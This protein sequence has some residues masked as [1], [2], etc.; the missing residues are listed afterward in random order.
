MVVTLVTASVALGGSPAGFVPSAGA[1]TAA[2]A[3]AATVLP[4]VSGPLVGGARTGRPFMSAFEDLA[5]LGY[6]EEEYLLSGV[7]TNN[8]L[9][10]ALD[11][12]SPVLFRVTAAPERTAPFT[13][14][15]QVIRPVDP[16]D[17][18][19]TALV[20]WNNVTGGLDAPVLWA[21]TRE[22]ILADGYA[23]V[24]VTAQKTGAMSG[25]LSL[26]NWDRVR[27]RGVSHPG[28][29]FAF[30]IFTQAAR[31]VK[32][33]R[34]G[35][36]DP[37]GGLL[38]E[39]VI[40][41]GASQSG[42]T[43]NIYIDHVQERAG[44]VDGFMPTVSAVAKVR[45]DL[46]PVLWVDS[47]AETLQA[48]EGH[49]PDSGLYRMWEIAGASHVDWYALQALVYMALRSVLPPVLHPLLPAYDADAAIQYGERSYGGSCPQNYFP[50]R[51]ALKAALVSVDRW[52]RTGLP[53]ASVP[54][55]VRVGGRPARDEHGNVLGGL[56]L[57]PIDV[58]I[59][60]YRATTCGLFGLTAR[61]SP[62]VLGELYPTHD[63][64]VAQMQAAA[65]D[66]VARGVL[67][68]ADA[69]ELMTMAEASGI[70][71]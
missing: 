56:R 37:M 4:E 65:D 51:Y 13:T 5:G 3:A 29:D 52:V 42:Y 38:V 8:G 11:L 15:I 44:V 36:V 48:P 45:D 46:V 69:A 33:G 53:P 22:Q 17:F 34:G 61:F 9:H 19:G 16:A 59:A 66:A 6:V 67:L 50:D 21:E 18:N 60:N 40:A 10:V 63:A 20:E 24:G 55:F 31:T 47:E 71:G 62:E 68:P 28:D 64:Y 49:A 14:R 7:A 2:S 58:P 27:Y 12:L 54:R 39:R 32:S 35:A 43:L 57:P 30:D 26:V 70:G 25:F 23:W 41:T 1:E